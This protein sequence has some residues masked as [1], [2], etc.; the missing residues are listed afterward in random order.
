MVGEPKAKQLL[1]GHSPG[2]DGL[3]PRSLRRNPRPFSML[4]CLCAECCPVEWPLGNTALDSEFAFKT[5]LA[6]G[7]GLQ[8]PSISPN[9]LAPI[10]KLAEQFLLRYPPSPPPQ[11]EGTVSAGVPAPGLTGPGGG[12]DPH[13]HTP[14]PAPTDFNQSGNESVSSG[15]QMVDLPHLSF[16]FR[17]RTGKAP[18]HWANVSWKHWR[19]LQ[20]T[21]GTPP[22]TETRLHAPSTEQGPGLSLEADLDTLEDARKDQ[23]ADPEAVH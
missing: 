20:S 4:R 3:P 14:K 7:S 21:V 11:G 23:G 17:R 9:P 5:L 15:N 18:A 1:G 19:Q 22:S 6:P 13:P 2:R 16:A 8:G 12:F 10:S